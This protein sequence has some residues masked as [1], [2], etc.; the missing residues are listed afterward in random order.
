[1]TKLEKTYL[2]Q[3]IGVFLLIIGYFRLPVSTFL[4][5]AILG[6]GALIYRWKFLRVR[7]DILSLKLWQ[8]L[9]LMVFFAICLFLSSIH[10]TNPQ[11]SMEAARSQVH[12][13]R[14]CLFLLVL[15]NNRRSFYQA[16][17]GAFTVGL[18]VLLID[19][20]ASLQL[21]LA[22]KRM[23]V[24]GGFMNHN[25]FAA[26]LNLVLPWTAVGICKYTQHKL[27]RC[28]GLLVVLAGVAAVGL[29]GSRGGLVSLAV[30]LIL[31]ALV[32]KVS[33]RY[34][35][36]GGLVL[37]LLGGVVVQNDKLAKR[38]FYLQGKTD[39]VAA[40]Q[41]QVHAKESG[42]FYVWQGAWNMFKDNQL[43]GVGLYNFNANYKNKYMLKDARE[44]EL[45]HAHN[46][47]LQRLAETGLIGSLGFWVLLIYQLVYLFRNRNCGEHHYIVLAGLMAMIVALSHGM[48][49]Y[50]FGLALYNRIFWMQWSVCYCCGAAGK[51]QEPVRKEV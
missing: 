2:I 35:A 3:N 49:D 6:F 29:S 33:W 43:W 31:L 26:F 47:I 46:T 19:A 21:Y 18:L 34:L 40:A 8:P 45:E 39:S 38:L 1:M 4:T 28:A 41:Q 15:F 16:V 30:A 42:R 24:D 37:L 22:H 5:G 32:Q 9:G 51:L 23:F 50:F 17:C 11:L 44:P 12:W 14:P 10:G 7:P 36:V 13:W 48:V 27:V 20:R 25:L